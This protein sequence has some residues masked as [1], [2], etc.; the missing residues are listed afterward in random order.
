MQANVLS[1]LVL[2]A[3]CCVLLAPLVWLGT[4]AVQASAAPV[5]VAGLLLAIACSLSA[6]GRVDVVILG[7]SAL[8]A[9]LIATAAALTGG[10]ASVC[11]W[12]LVL[13]PAEALRQGRRMVA[14]ASGAFGFL[15][16][17]ATAFSDWAAMPRSMSHWV[18]G[19]DALSIAIAVL[20]GAVL[21]RRLGLGRQA[22]KAKRVREDAERALADA[23]LEEA[24]MLFSHEGTLLKSSPATADLFSGSSPMNASRIVQA[25]HVTDRV[26]YLQA[27]AEI[28]NGSDRWVL[29][30]RASGGA[31][32][33]RDVEIDL[34]AHRDR[35][36]R[37]VSIVVVARPAPVAGEALAVLERTLA[38]ERESSLAKSR[39]LATVSH[40]LRTPLNAIIGF[41][42]VLDQEF[43][44]GFQDPRQKEYV[45]HI[46]QSGEHL[47]GVVN[48]LLDVSKIEA[49]RY[50]LA[51]E[52]V[53]VDEICRSADGTM[54]GELARKG[55][56]F[57][58]KLE[59][60]LGRI[61]ADRR[62]CHQM[63]LNLL[64][65]AAKF[66]EEGS[67]T[68]SA[69]K[70]GP[71]IELSVR[72]TG[73]GI[74]ASDLSRVGQPFVQLS[75]GTTR[76]YQGTGLGLSLVRGLADLHDGR[77]TIESEPGVGTTVRVLLPL[78]G[79]ARI[80]HSS[81]STPTVVALAH[82]RKKS[83]TPSTDDDQ[84]RRTA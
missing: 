39:F 2:S 25:I 47:L 22:E 9:A 36:G 17:G 60:A 78:D 18:S 7:I 52:T 53:S 82:A 21:T 58:L 4:N 70:V 31:G 66:T 5:I 44:G 29:R 72:D 42:D 81:P 75:S 83:H 28:R 49:G 65:N 1:I 46:R 64:S 79:P 14:T 43:F 77:M 45:G 68:L 23:A 26:S 37:L 71:H 38:A 76:R 50:E 11:L 35:Q 56:S 74:A 41:S 19:L 8:A 48:G 40:E 33:F 54:R 34:R 62:A 51:L 15:A 20:Y 3:L 32:T 69:R 12:M 57:E 55:L 84:A 67:V 59:P 24:V 27:F 80:D 16:L 63:L 13:A 30:A 10:V 61:V 6:T 73:I